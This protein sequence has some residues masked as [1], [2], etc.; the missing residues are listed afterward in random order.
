MEGDA[1]E[2]LHRA[3]E[4]VDSRQLE[5]RRGRRGAGGRGGRRPVEPQRR[6]AAEIG[7]DDGRVVLHR[8]RRPGGDDAAVVE[9]DDVVREGH[10]EVELVLDQEDRQALAAQRGD[11]LEH[12]ARLDRVHAGGRL[13]EEEQARPEREGAADLGPAPVR[14]RERV[15]VLLAARQEALAEARELGLDGG[16]RRASSAR[17]ARERISA[18]AVSAS[19][20]AQRSRRVSRQRRSGRCTTSRVCMPTSR[21]SSTVMLPKTRPFWNVRA[22]PRGGDPVGAEAGHRV[23]GEP[24]LAGVG[25]HLPA[26][27]VEGGRLA[28][29]VRADDADDLARTDDERDVVDRAHAAEVLDEAADLEQRRFAR[30]AHR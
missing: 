4:D 23:P 8:R 25:A 14:I 7:L 9:D 21:F 30:G 19:S 18:T 20:A 15:G 3:V 17:T 10:D 13:V 26:H 1:G 12:L 28:R 22:R 29:A 27:Q 16:A 2:R 24:D 6:A 5:Q 11:L